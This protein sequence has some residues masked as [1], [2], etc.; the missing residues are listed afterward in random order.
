MDSSWLAPAALLGLGVVVNTALIWRLWTHYNRLTG[1]VAKKELM[2]A[3]N[4]LLKDVEENKLHT[5]NLEKKFDE[6]QSR[7]MKNYR[8]L[9]F[10]RFNPF[11]DTGGNQSFCLA[12][13][14]AHNDG[15]MI[16]SLHSRENTRL[17]SKVISNGKCADQNLS[18]EEQEVLN[19]ALKQ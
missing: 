13:L 5:E 16:S 1:K 2:D 7:G 6:A 10:Q 8:K 9:G 14:D 15:F 3:L 4:Q 19:Q 17:Y 18:K 12:L 11:A